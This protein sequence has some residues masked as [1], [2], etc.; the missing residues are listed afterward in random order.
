MYF[1]YFRA[2]QFELI[3]LRELV[4]GGKLKDKIMPVFEPV[5]K[6]L[7]NFEVVNRVFQ[8]NQFKAFI[9]VNPM[10]GEITGDTNY[11][12]DYIGNLKESSFV[13][14]FHFTKNCDFINQSMDKYNLTGCL[15][16]NTTDFSDEVLF[17]EMSNNNRITHVM[18]KDAQKYRSLD[19]YFKDSK[20]FYIKLDDLFDKQKRNEDYLGISAHKFSEEHLYYR[21]EGYDGFSDFTVL[22]SEF[23]DGGSTPRA[24]V[25]HLTYLNQEDEN[26]IWIRH[27]TSDTN[28]V[29]SNVQGKFAE[30]AKKAI[31]YCD[32]Q[33][34]SNVAIEELKQYLNEKKYPGLGIVKKISIKNHLIVANLFLS[35]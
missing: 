6:S 35:N 24:V 26:S 12:L 22:P 23:S 2:R 8:E 15:L 7:S 33:N 11:Y 9:I 10:T 31:K 17:K 32:S 3:A 30:A 16:I 5:R 13:P 28:G 19:R 34:I 21:S 4:K 20:K 1:P 14:A 29:I 27:F 25:I 18:I